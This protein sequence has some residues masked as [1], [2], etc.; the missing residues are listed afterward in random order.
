MEG[1]H[2][3]RQGRN[4][5]GDIGYGGPCPPRGTHRYFFRIYALDT[6]INPERGALRSTVLKAMEDHV[7]AEGVLVGKYARSAR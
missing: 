2:T 4:D 5:F 1:G 3:L 7:L 6:V